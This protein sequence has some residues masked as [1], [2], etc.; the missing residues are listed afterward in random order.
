MWPRFRYDRSSRRM[1]TLF[2]IFFIIGTAILLF[3]MF[4]DSLGDQMPGSCPRCGAPDTELNP[5]VAVAGYVR[6][7]LEFSVGR[8]RCRHCQTVFRNHPNG[9]LVEDHDA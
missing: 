5:G 8:C 4:F 3:S 2:W 6:W 9:S 1:A 7:Y